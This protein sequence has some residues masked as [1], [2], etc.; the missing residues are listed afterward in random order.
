LYLYPITDGCLYFMDCIMEFSEE[1]VLKC[2]Q[3]ELHPTWAYVFVTY[4]VLTVLV[5]YWKGTAFQEAAARN[6]LHLWGNLLK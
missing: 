1:T 3:I 4:C 5:V 2:A 6:M